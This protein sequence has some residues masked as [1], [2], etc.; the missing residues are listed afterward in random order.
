MYDWPETEPALD[1]L[2]ALTADELSKH[3]LDAPAHLTRDQDARTLWKDPE[4]LIGQTCGWPYANQLRGLVHP[5][6][7]FDYGLAKC[8][9]GF[10]QSVF[11][12]R[13]ASDA[14]FIDNVANLAA[15]KKVAINGADSQSGFHVFAEISGMQAGAS[16]PEKSRVLTGAHRNS[17]KAVAGGDAHIAAIDAVAFELA[18]THEADAVANVVV[19]GHSKPKPGLPLITSFEFIDQSD[20]LFSSLASAIEA[21]PAEHKTALHING[22]V[23]AEDADYDVFINSQSK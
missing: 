18:K 7:R 3:G 12:G 22:I 6:A 4:L 20:I 13:D 5:F 19:L 1:A 2:W 8:P 21:L 15:C 16:I 11:I 17:V 9:P 10:Y 23:L 14:Q